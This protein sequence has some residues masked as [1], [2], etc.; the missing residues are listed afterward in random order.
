[1]CIY[2]FEFDES[3]SD[4]SPSKL[5][6]F[7]VHSEI[8]L[9]RFPTLSFP[10]SSPILPLGVGFPLI[11]RRTSINPPPHTTGL[12]FTTRSFVGSN[13]I[14]TQFVRADNLYSRHSITVGHCQNQALRKFMG[15]TW[16]LSMGGSKL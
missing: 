6:P 5:L 1:M 3:F 12:L 9:N 7:V 8:S 11:I 2:L 16:T 10:F 4:Y 14:F 13:H 15:I